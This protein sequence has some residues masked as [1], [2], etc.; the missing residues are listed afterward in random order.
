MGRGG[1]GRGGGGGLQPRGRR[2]LAGGRRGRGASLRRRRGGL[3]AARGR[4][5][6]RGGRRRRR[7]RRGGHA[8]GGGSSTQQGEAST[9]EAGEEGPEAGGEDATDHEGGATEEAGSEGGGGSTNEAG[10]DATAEAAP[11]ASTSPEASTGEAGSEAGADSSAT[12]ASDAGAEATADASEDAP[13]VV[14]PVCDGAIG[15][16][17][18]GG[19]GNQAAATSGQT[20]YVTWDAQN[21]YVAIANANVLEGSILYV[22][23]DPLSPTPPANGTTSGE[24]YDST[25]V[26]TLP[27]AAQLVVYAHDG[28]TESRVTSGSTWGSPDTV[29]VTLCDDATTQTREEV[30]PWSLLGGRPGNFGWTGYLAANGNANPQGYIYGQMPTD[31]PSGSP[32]NAAAF[33]TYFYVP[34]GAGVPTSPFSDEK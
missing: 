3:D 13:S 19:A 9:V 5:R 10:L 18:Y 32:A 33:T 30:I 4:R 27:F 16:G 15:A 28:Y 22:A 21:L 8:R 24:L 34:D 31:D 6:G 2:V 14:A 12:D 20:W 17:E 29:S 26:T 11:E 1:L 23:V 25:D 7:G